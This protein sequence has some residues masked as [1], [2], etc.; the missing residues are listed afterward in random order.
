VLL[1]AVATREEARRLEHDGD[2]EVA[3]RQG[4]RVALGQDADLAAVDRD[5]AVGHPGCRGSRGFGS[6]AGSAGVGHRVGPRLWAALEPY[7]SSL[8]PRW[9]D[10]L[11]LSSLPLD[12]WTIFGIAG[13]GVCIV[14]RPAIGLS[15]GVVVALH[16]LLY[17]LIALGIWNWIRIRV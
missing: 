8:R 12:L 4:R 7:V 17:F 14:R 3:P 5:A 13:L 1:R 16:F 6:V 15:L 10:P 9:R 11:F 2:V